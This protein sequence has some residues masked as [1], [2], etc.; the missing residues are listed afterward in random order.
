MKENVVMPKGLPRSWECVL[1]VLG[2]IILFPILLICA[3]LVRFS[4]PGPIFFR[5]KRVGFKGRIFTLYKFRT[6]VEA[7]KGPLITADGDRRITRIGR[8]LRKLKLDEL[9]EIYNVLRGDM[10]LV[11]PRPEVPQYVDFSNPLWDRVLSVRPGI[12]DPVTLR[13][14]NEEAFLAQVEDKERFYKEKIQPFKLKQSIKYLEKRS[15]K[16]DIKVIGKTFYVILFPHTA[17]PPSVE[18]IQPSYLK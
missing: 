10:A 7:K 4:S 12:T 3:L 16:K 6:M 15:I 18:E 8:I 2:L 13:L 5:Q 9:P 17:P 11:G 14:R 1:A